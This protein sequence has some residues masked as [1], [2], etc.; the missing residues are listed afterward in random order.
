M[1]LVG[2]VP[3]CNI[4]T[5][6]GAGRSF[7][8]VIADQN[9]KPIDITGYSFTLTLYSLPINLEG[10]ISGSVVYTKSTP[11]A[12][13]SVPTPTSG[14]VQWAFLTADSLA[15]PIGT[16]GYRLVGTVGVESYICL[17]GDVYHTSSPG[18]ESP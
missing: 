10:S 9:N 2:D 8:F 14:G 7:L 11:S 18:T 15:L 16:Y 13:L 5:Y 6:R 17:M 3:A 12:S 4:R 1:S